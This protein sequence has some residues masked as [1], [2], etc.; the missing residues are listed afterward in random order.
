MCHPEPPPLPGRQTRGKSHGRRY[1]NRTAKPHDTAPKSKLPKLSAR[2]DS[3]KSDSAQHQPAKSQHA[4]RPPIKYTPC[5]RKPE[6]NSQSG[7]GKQHSDDKPAP[8]K[9]Q[10]KQNG[11]K[12][13]NQSYAKGSS[14]NGGIQKKQGII[15]IMTGPIL[16]RIISPRTNLCFFWKKYSNNQQCQPHT[17]GS[18]DKHRLHFPPQIQPASRKRSDKHCNME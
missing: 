5:N 9:G 18:T 3:I 16:F 2:S 10:R 11:I 17:A 15:S 6:T 7:N 13:R 12:S 1:R 14:G 4:F 8:S